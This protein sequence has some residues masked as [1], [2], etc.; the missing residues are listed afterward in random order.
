M[1]QIFVS[2]CLL[3]FSFYA[4]AMTAAPPA[5][6]FATFVYVSQSKNGPTVTGVR[7]DTV[8]TANSDSGVYQL[9]T[10]I[11]IAGQVSQTSLWNL[12]G[13]YFNNTLYFIEHCKESGGKTADIQ[14]PAGSFHTCHIVFKSPDRETLSQEVWLSPDVPLFT[15]KQIRKASDAQ[16]SQITTTLS[17]F[18]QK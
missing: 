5:G 14:V 2:L 18:S 16:Q 6:S 13:D 9:Q 12:S 4:Q 15:V 3:L 1:P 11:T 17:Q 7:T 10:Q 8:M